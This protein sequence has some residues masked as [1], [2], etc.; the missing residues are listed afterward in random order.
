[1]YGESDI[2][3]LASQVL[4][5]HDGKDIHAHVDSGENKE[6][7]VAP[8]A[9]A[10]ATVSKFNKAIVDSAQRVGFWSEEGRGMRRLQQAVEE[11]AAV[12]QSLAVREQSLSISQLPSTLLPASPQSQPAAGAP[13]HAT[14][15][16]AALA[17]AAVQKPSEFGIDSAAL[18]DSAATAQSATPASAAAPTPAPAPA[19]AWVE[20]PAAAPSRIQPLLNKETFAAKVTRLRLASPYGHL[21]G[22]KVAGLIAKS[23]DDVRQEVRT[24]ICGIYY[25]CIY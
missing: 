11:T 18:G 13:S 9:G 14:T 7:V 6:A 17:P 2:K 16:P 19:V 1:M 3:L 8:A 15:P 12:E 10:A 21:P 20:P 4:Y 5:D 22:Y 23:N 24:A 25:S